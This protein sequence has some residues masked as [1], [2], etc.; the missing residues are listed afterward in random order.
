MDRTLKELKEIR[1][2]TEIRFR[3]LL[4]DL[5]GERKRLRENA[6][7][8]RAALK[9]L[10]GDSAEQV[11]SVL[12]EMLNLHEGCLRS[13]ERLIEGLRELMALDN[14]RSAELARQLTVLPL[15]RMDL[16]LDE[17]ERRLEAQECEMRRLQKKTSGAPRST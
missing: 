5:D 8:L 13:Q 2:N 3:T 14:A 17:F 9:A 6:R 15:E 12:N 10:S 16:A 7:R 4:D 11:G 1:E